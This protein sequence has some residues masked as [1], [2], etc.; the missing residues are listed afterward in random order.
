MNMGAL[1]LELTVAATSENV[2][3]LRHAT[4]AY[5]EELGLDG[6]TLNDALLAVT[7]ACSNVVRHA[8]EGTDGKMTLSGSAVD[9]QVSLIV[10]DGGRGFTPRI[11]SPGLGIG[12]P[13]ISAL[14]TSV[15]IRASA[16]GGTE[17]AMTFP[18]SS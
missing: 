12:I 6:A 7:E 15:E 2:P 13:L 14:A 17:V 10:G 1:G 11:D 3:L 18:R 8:Y 16:A 4:R 5:L 9:H